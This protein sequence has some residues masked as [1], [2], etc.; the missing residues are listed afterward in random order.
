MDEMYLDDPVSKSWNA[1]HTPTTQW[2]QNTLKNTLKDIMVNKVWGGHE[3]KLKTHQLQLRTAV[4]ITNLIT[5]SLRLFVM[6]LLNVVAM[7]MLVMGLALISCS[8]F[9]KFSCLSSCCA[10]L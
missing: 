5:M 9:D 1:F 6:H 8:L 4:F 7:E 2:Q 10:L 3:W